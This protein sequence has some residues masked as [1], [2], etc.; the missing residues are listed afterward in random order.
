MISRHGM[1]FREWAR[2]LGLRR[3]PGKTSGKAD[4]F[5]AR[6]GRKTHSA[7]TQWQNTKWV[8]WNPYLEVS[9][10]DSPLASVMALVPLGRLGETHQTRTNTKQH[11]TPHNDTTTRSPFSLRVSL[12][13]AQSTTERSIHTEHHDTRE[14]HEK[15]SWLAESWPSP[16]LTWAA[17]WWLSRRASPRGR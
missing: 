15:E 3:A 14:P 6:L 2:M 9:R 5:Y 16:P 10:D 13:Q 4:L 17:K 8:T 1:H 11:E 12:P 7:Q